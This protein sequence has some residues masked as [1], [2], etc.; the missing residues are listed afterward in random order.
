[1]INP[2][3][4]A[5]RVAFQ[6]KLQQAADTAKSVADDARKASAWLAL[7][8][9]IWNSSTMNWPISASDLPAKS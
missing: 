9:T 2:A 7:A 4:L 5:N 6:S 8:S 1:M 3:L